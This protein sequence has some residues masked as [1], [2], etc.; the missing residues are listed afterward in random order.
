MKVIETDFQQLVNSHPE[1]TATGYGIDVQFYP[2]GTP[3]YDSRSASERPLLY[4]L[5]PQYAYCCDWLMTKPKML[6]SRRN[7]HG[8]K[9]DVERWLTSVG[10]KHNYIPQGAF[11]LAAL[12]NGY[13]IRE[14]YDDSPNVRLKRQRP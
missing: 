8:F 14:T 6:I 4:Q 3:E 2:E 11:I 13:Q 7:S 10:V 9:H 12:T 5:Y 1:L